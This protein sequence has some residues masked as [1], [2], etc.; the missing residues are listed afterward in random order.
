MSTDDPNAL[1]A[2]ARTGDLAAFAELLQSYRPRMLRLVE[3]QMS[4]LLRQ[5]LDPR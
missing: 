1:V 3:R 4:P 5:K 2:K